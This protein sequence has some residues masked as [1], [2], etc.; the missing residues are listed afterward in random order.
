M[1]QNVIENVDLDILKFMS[2]RNNYE[3]YSDVIHKGLCTKESWTLVQDY[4]KYFEEY[5]NATNIDTDFDLWF[6]VQGHPGWKPEQHQIYGTILSNVQQRAFPQ[7]DVFIDQLERLRFQAIAEKAIGELAQGDAS[8][9]DVIARLGKVQTNPATGAVPVCSFTLDDLAQHQ[10]SSDG[11][12]WRLEDLNKAVG[13]IRKGDFIIVGKRP[14]VGGTS[15]IC[16][17]MSYMC[18]QLGT[19]NAVL[20]N[21]EEAPD[22]VFTRMVSGALGV[23]YRTMMKAHKL[24]QQQYETWL[25]GREWDLVH[26]TSMDIRSIHRTLQGKQYDLIGINVLLKVGGTDAKEDHDKFQA[27]GEE[28]RRISQEYGPVLAVVQADPSAEGIR[29]IPQDRIYKSKTALQGEADVLLM[30][31]SDDEN[32]PPDSRYIHVAKNKIPPASCCDL[33]VKHIKSE[34]S[35]DLGTGRFESK[36]YTGNSRSKK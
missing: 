24:H 11:L 13:P 2:N 17:E 19:G 28:M 4:G 35:F 5:P 15:F 6:R 34:V 27:L 8:P 16:S 36:N 26:D 18:E 1:G 33:A 12:Y 22:K 10:R 20:F 31:G 29:Y 3:T 14:E 21:N 30:I 7:R 23:D 25:D 32:G 9:E